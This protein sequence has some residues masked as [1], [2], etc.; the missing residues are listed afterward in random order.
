LEAIGENDAIY[1]LLVSILSKNQ[2]DRSVVHHEPV[3]RQSTLDA[4]SLLQGFA[5][6]VSERTTREAVGPVTP[7]KKRVRFNGN[8]GD[9]SHS[10]VQ[11][12][13][14]ALPSK[15]FEY[16]SCQIAHI[17]TT[18]PNQQAMN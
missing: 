8:E 12:T 10:V 1:K 16:V 11:Q 2:T 6:I 4:A 3:E 17:L 9:E 5:Q 18:T 15:P 14:P 7:V 13:D